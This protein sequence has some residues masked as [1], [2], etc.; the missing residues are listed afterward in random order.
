MDSR[1]S[2]ESE[3]A[4]TISEIDLAL[5]DIT[6]PQEKVQY[7][8]EELRRQ[9]FNSKSQNKANLCLYL[10]WHLYSPWHL[11]GEPIYILPLE[12]GKQ[13]EN[14]RDWVDSEICATFNKRK[15]TTPPAPPFMQDCVRIV[16][17]TLAYA[18]RNAQL[19]AMK[20]KND[21]LITPKYLIEEFG[22]GKLKHTSSHFREI[23]RS[24]HRDTIL[25]DLTNK[26][27]SELKELY[28]ERR[29]T[30][31]NSIE[32]NHPNT[33]SDIFL[34]GLDEKQISAIRTALQKLPIR[35]Y[36][37]QLSQIQREAILNL[38]PPVPDNDDGDSF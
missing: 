22:F 7:L 14:I 1:S 38:L 20:D 35:R 10:L 18:H 25:F 11:Y 28:S 21:N 24:N 30:P 29:V 5:Q 23:S 4:N 34:F 2:S 33:G 6:T 26:T 16:E 8:R 37:I 31:I 12:N 3:P 32:S 36:N 9:I 17:H 27:V 19:N 15:A 13:Y